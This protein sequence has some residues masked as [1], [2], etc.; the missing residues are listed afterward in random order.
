MMVIKDIQHHWEV[1]LYITLHLY[2]PKLNG[3][4][5]E[6]INPLFHGLTYRKKSMGSCRVTQLLLS[7]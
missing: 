2:R 3:K 1:M 6:I 5:V 4:I 7:Q